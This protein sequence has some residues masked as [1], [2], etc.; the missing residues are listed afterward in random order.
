VEIKHKIDLKI[1]SVSP[2]YLN[3]Q[4]H[5]DKSNITSCCCVNHGE[6]LINAYFSKETYVAGEKL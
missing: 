3:P 2:I 4:K 6:S 5:T 1:K